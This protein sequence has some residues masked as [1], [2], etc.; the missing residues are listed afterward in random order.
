MM[1][2]MYPF[3]VALPVAMGLGITAALVIGG[4]LWYM[5]IADHINRD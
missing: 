2:E 5:A 3:V 4:S 1:A